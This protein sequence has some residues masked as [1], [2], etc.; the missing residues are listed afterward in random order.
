ME[1]DKLRPHCCCIAPGSIW[2]YVGN[3]L[4]AP[5]APALS[6][7]P[8]SLRVIVSLTHKLGIEVGRKDEARGLRHDVGSPD[9]HDFLPVPFG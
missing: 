4:P 8:R 7:D 3:H 2:V 9:I 5:T 6:G 1:G